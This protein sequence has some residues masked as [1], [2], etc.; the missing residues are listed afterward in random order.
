MYGRDLRTP[1]YGPPGS[2]IYNKIDRVFEVAFC[3]VNT[4][5]VG[6]PWLVGVF[7]VALRMAVR[8]TIR[9]PTFCNPFLLSA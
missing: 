1:S 6:F 5:G 4:L 7:M 8:L 2:K 3:L 9:Q